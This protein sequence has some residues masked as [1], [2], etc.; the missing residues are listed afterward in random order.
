[1]SGKGYQASSWSIISPGNAEAWWHNS[2]N[3]QTVPVQTLQYDFK[4][5][6]ATTDSYNYVRN[7]ISTHYSESGA[8][9]N[10]MVRVANSN[11]NKSIYLDG[12]DASVGVPGTHPDLGV[13]YRLQI[14]MDFQQGIAKARFGQIDGQGNASYNDWSGNI[15]MKSTQQYS[16]VRLGSNGQVA[17][18]NVTLV[19]EPATTEKPGNTSGTLKQTPAGRFSTPAVRLFPGTESR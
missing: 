17:Y 15:T 5:I 8:D 14:E 1:M 12:L 13:W 4:Q 10:S 6:S 3:V 18:D 9:W 7:M 11:G 2:L 16:L 19:P